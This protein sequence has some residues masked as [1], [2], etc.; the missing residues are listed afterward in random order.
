[1]MKHEFLIAAKKPL[2]L[3]LAVFV[4]I[5]CGNP[6][7]ESKKKRAD[8]AKKGKGD[9]VVAVVWPRRAQS[10]FLFT[11]GV[12]L[13]VRQINEK[14]GVLGRRLRTIY[15]E[16]TQTP[17]GHFNAKK[18]ADHA[19]VVAVVGHVHSD[20]T[21][22]ALITY[23]YNGIL[24]LIGAATHPLLLE[25]EFEYVFRPIPNDRVFGERLAQYAH[26]TGYKRIAIIDDN[27]LY[28]NGLADNF[29][30][31]A[32]DLGLDM[33]IHR[34]YL[35]WQNNFR[36]LIAQIKKLE[37]DAIFLSGALPQAGTF[38]KQLRQ[39]GVKAPVMAGGGLGSQDFIA[40]A[41]EAANGT[42]VPTMF[43]PAPSDPAYLKFMKAFRTKYGQAPDQ[44]AA[45]G[46]DTINLLDAVMTDSG[47]TVPLVVASILRHT[48]D[49][50]GVMGNY[51]FEKDGELSERKIFF[52]QVR[53]GQFIDIKE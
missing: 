33:V 50:Q 52:K 18:I 15:Y 35:P 40:I 49:W 42:V 34:G 41:G 39:M 36:P 17:E 31:K 8:F 44:Y 7:A 25:Q 10:P 4:L 48:Q 5:G 9:V 28:G 21:L 20:S 51:A 23:E 30:Q 3:L 26:G 45:L 38:M 14:G 29:Y 22:S 46:Y 6:Y 16:D 43:R 1:M 24:L 47:S 53:D 32:T 2:F 27:T 37:F 12:D 11:E 19:E 13:A